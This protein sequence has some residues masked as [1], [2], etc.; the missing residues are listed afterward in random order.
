M[1]I[2]AEIKAVP[3]ASATWQRF[4]LR[5]LLVAGLFFILLETAPPTFYHLSNR[6]NTLLTARLMNLVNIRP[7][8]NDTL[9][10]LDGFTVNVI[11]ECSALFLLALLTSFI[12]AYPAAWRQKAAGLLI[13]LPMVMVVNIARIALV[14]YIGSQYRPLFTPLHL[15]FGQV[16]MIVAVLGVV[17]VWLRRLSTRDEIGSCLGFPLRFVLFT[18]PL[19]LFWLWAAPVY[20]TLANEIAFR[21]LKGLQLFN[22][23]K[24]VWP[25]DPAIPI[26]FNLVVFCGL[27]LASRSRPWV[28]KLIG[29][30]AGTPVLIAGH[31][32]LKAG[33]LF[34]LQHQNAWLMH[35]LNAWLLTNQWLLPMGGWFIWRM[36]TDSKITKS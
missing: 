32:S 3:A 15:Y 1:P 30:P 31:L 33:H 36:K 16:L 28:Q 10:T 6:F 13:C 4:A 26:T 29:I 9:L 20:A 22:L 17:Q 7:V 21:T 23:A 27:I 14:F 11:G 25:S 2:V 24:P 19:F 12:L 35:G 18:S 5:F 8:I 34:F